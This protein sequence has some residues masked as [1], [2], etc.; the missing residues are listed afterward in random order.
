MQGEYY[1]LWLFS[2]F[3]SRILLVLFSFLREFVLFFAM[4]REGYSWLCSFFYS[5]LLEYYWY[6]IRIF[7]RSKWNKENYSSSSNIVLY[8]VLEN[9][10][11]AD[12]KRIEYFYGW[13][14]KKKMEHKHENNKKN[15]KSKCFFFFFFL[16][17]EISFS[18]RN[19]CLCRDFY[20]Y[21]TDNRTVHR[22]LTFISKF[23]LEIFSSRLIHPTRRRVLTIC[24]D[25][26]VVFQPLRYLARRNYVR[27]P[28]TYSI[29]IHVPHP[30]VSQDFKRLSLARKLFGRYDWTLKNS[31][32][33]NSNSIDRNNNKFLECKNFDSIQSVELF[34]RSEDRVE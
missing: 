9:R 16:Y 20:F 30:L 34:K 18:N 26:G 28:H 14:D 10:Y 3:L 4:Q 21:F 15:I 6:L 1:S 19:Y 29:N 8:N 23:D 27:H 32:T 13:R 22:T 5:F 7:W 31:S 25:V 2:L 24:R 33:K 12:I 17:L 11:V